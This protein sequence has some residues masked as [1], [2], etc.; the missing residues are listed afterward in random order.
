MDGNIM[1]ATKDFVRLENVE[2]K[3]KFVKFLML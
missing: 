1:V 2:V 3:I